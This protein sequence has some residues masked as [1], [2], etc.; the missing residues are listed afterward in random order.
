MA[1]KARPARRKTKPTR[2]KAKPAKKAEARTTAPASRPVR[3]LAE[4]LATDEP[5]WP[6]VQGWIGAATK[7]VEVHELWRQRTEIEG[8]L[9]DMYPEPLDDLPTAGRS[10]PV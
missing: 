9:R 3:S 2:R 4:L 8:D 10:R 1:R 7:P 5:A 6:M